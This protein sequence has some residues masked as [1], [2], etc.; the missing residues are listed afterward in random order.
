MEEDN[1]VS[2]I[3]CLDNSNLKKKETKKIKLPFKKVIQ[4]DKFNYYFPVQI[5]NHV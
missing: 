3:F 5:R 4:S 1:C 2:A